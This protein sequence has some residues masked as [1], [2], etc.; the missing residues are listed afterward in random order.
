VAAWTPF[1]GVL[2]L[3]WHGASFEVVRSLIEAGDLPALRRL[4]D[5]DVQP[6]PPLAPSLASKF[7]RASRADHGVTGV[8]VPAL[9]PPDT[10]AE[11]SSGLDRSL[12]KKLLSDAPTKRT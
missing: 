6:L 8:R 4:S 3:V 10:L 11:S 5:A 1:R 9:D 12:V 7:T 2:W